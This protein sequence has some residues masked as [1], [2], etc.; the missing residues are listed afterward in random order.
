MFFAQ[1]S[2]AI[3]QERFEE[4]AVVLM[5]GAIGGLATALLSD[6]VA[7]W[8][9]RGNREEVLVAAF[10]KALD[11]LT[12]QLGPDMLDWG[13][14]R[15]H[16]MVQKHF[17][18][19]RGELGLLLDRGG[20]P[21]K[22]DGVTVCN[23]GFDPNWGAS[24]GAGYR[25]IADLSDPRGTLRAV[26][27]GSESGHPGSPHYDDQLTGW[28]TG[29]YHELPLAPDSEPAPRARLTLEPA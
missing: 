6:D 5:S 2:R 24:M 8:F 18:S 12:Q 20:V 11:I 9:V 16:K 7:G 29:Q 3:A 22:G 27:A 4:E 15:I 21:V 10:H 28:L 14:G 19:D 23:T 13:W 26:D 17:L 25:L 1:W